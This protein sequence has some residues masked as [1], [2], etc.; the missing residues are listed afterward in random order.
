MFW[1]ILTAVLITAGCY[2]IWDWGLTSLFTYLGE[3]M[4]NV[5]HV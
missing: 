1:V 2:F 5:L 3:K 4:G